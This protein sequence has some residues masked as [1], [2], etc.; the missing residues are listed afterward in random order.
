MKTTR[1]SP[2]PPT[3]WTLVVNACRQGTAE[4]QQR[5]LESL[6]RDYWYPLYAFARRSG[7]RSEDAED[8]TQGFFHYLLERD[9]VASANQELG[10]LRTFLLTAFQRYIGDVRSR[11]QALKRGGGHEILSLDVEAAERQFD[12]PLEALTP[13]EIFDRRWAQT[14]LQVTLV[15]LQESEIAA[16]K[17]DQFGILESFLRPSSTAE[18]NYDEIASSLE[19][20]SE[21]A[22]K[23]VSRLR[24]RFRDL[25]RTQIADTLTLPSKEQVDEELGALKIA[26]RG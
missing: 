1:I 21:A 13:H 10:K 3:Q 12:E 6:C 25:L 23:A 26:L 11:G 20:S 17:G 18:G 22:R 9:L 19:I 8:M 4:E 2:F 14:I 15:R 7:N 16:G 5:A 24:G